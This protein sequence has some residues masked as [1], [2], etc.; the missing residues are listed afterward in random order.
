[1]ITQCPCD[2]KVVAKIAQ[3]SEAIESQKSHNNET[4]SDSSNATVM[5]FHKHISI[6]T[7][8]CLVFFFYVLIFCKTEQMGNIY[9]ITSSSKLPVKK[10]NNNN[11]KL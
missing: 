10:N 6:N 1:M 4:N 11:N 7:L 5:Q 8:L 9:N 2:L 3:V